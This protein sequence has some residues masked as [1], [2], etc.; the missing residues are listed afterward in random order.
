M[1]E[2]VHLF[3]ISGSHSEDVQWNPSLMEHQQLDGVVVTFAKSKK[4]KTYDLL[5]AA[6]GL[7]SKICGMMLNS[8]PREQL[9]M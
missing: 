2:R 5:V 4:V 7:G 9:F 3:S 8:K 6:D 1:A